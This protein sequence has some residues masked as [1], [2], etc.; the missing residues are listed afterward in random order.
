MHQQLTLL[1]PSEVK[2]FSSISRDFPNC[3]IMAI[4]QFEEK[5]LMN[6]CFLNNF[7]E[8]LKTDLVDYSAVQTYS[9]TTIYNI[10]DKVKLNAVYYVAIQSVTGIQPPNNLKW[11]VGQ[12]FKSN[13]FNELFCSYLARY[14]SE[15]VARK[16][17]TLGINNVI[18][19]KVGAKEMEIYLRSLD[20]LI[21]TI[22]ENMVRYMKKTTCLKKY[23]EAKNECGCEGEKTDCFDKK[24][25]LK[26]A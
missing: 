5:L 15:Y 9:N 12:K 21:N 20:D 13:C 8:D 10:N 11:A 24:R 26:F 7:Y 16:N 19:E 4:R 6:E 23:I 2:E 14:V 3:D 25:R 1:S 22:L 18:F 17:A